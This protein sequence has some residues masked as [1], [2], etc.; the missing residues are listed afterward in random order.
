MCFLKLLKHALKEDSCIYR[1]NHSLLIF[2]WKECGLHSPLDCNI[3]SICCGRSGAAWHRSEGS[4]RIQSIMPMGA[5]MW[6][7][8]LETFKLHSNLSGCTT[9][10]PWI[11]F[12]WLLLIKIPQF[13]H[14]PFFLKGLALITLIGYRVMFMCQQL[15]LHSVTIH[16]MTNSCEQNIQYIIHII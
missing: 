2:F 7:Q 4:H 5:E 1:K 16:A 9:V 3:F 13:P 12:T 15:K 6:F 14:G 8:I 10:Y 11:L